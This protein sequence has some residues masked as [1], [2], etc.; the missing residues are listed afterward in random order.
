MAERLS[1]EIAYL[2]K[3]ERDIRIL[4]GVCNLRGDFD[5]EK[6]ILKILDMAAEETGFDRKSKGSTE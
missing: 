3:V 5:Q 2:F 1:K 4:A 6:A